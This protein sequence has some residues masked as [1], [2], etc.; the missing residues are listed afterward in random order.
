MLKKI[1]PLFLLAG[2]FV[3]VSQIGIGT[4]TP[5]ASA[6][7]ELNSSNK[8]LLLPKVSLISTNQS[9]PLSAHLRG[10]IVYNTATSATEGGF[11]VTPGMYYND[12]SAW[13][14]M[15]TKLPVIGDIKYGLQPADHNGWYILDGR[16]TNSLSGS[17]A[18]IASSLGFTSNLP[19][20]R[21]RFLK[22]K[23]GVENI[24]DT[25]GTSTFFIAIENF[26]DVNFTGSTDSA[27]AH[28]HSYLDNL[29]TVNNYVAGA[30]NPLANTVAANFTTGS[31]GNHTHTASFSSGGS[32]TAVSFVP[33]HI[34]T[35]V[36]IYLG[37]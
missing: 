10:M 33:S 13:I 14:R 32:G 23:T 19:D 34:V 16:A 4:Q 27:G 36:F 2:H 25:G 37:I 17:A 11:E 12:G 18:T 26:P 30:D 29:T 24:G 35:N 15:T 7:L 8:G 6:L 1:L 28:T 22:S 3:A 5:N 9:A 21:D 20:A 31:A